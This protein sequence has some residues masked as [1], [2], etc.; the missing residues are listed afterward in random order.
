MPCS[1]FALDRA[2]LDPAKIRN[3]LILCSG[4]ICRSPMAEGYLRLQLSRTRKKHVR[5]LSAGT[6]GLINRDASEHAQTVATKNGF[7]LSQHRSF[8]A[9]SSIL[10][11]ADLILVMEEKHARFV[12]S[13]LPEKSERVFLLGSLISCESEDEIDDPIG[14][15]LEEYEAAFAKLKAGIDALINWLDGND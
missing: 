13:E 12:H 7:D 14:G 1:S 8:P 15:T 9:E 4:N 10:L 3:I 5:A 11:E 2:G 6:L